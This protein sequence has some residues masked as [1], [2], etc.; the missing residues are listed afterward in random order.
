MLTYLSN[1][2]FATSKNTT[3]KTNITANK[4]TVQKQQ[5]VSIEKNIAKYL[6]KVPRIFYIIPELNKTKITKL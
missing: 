6:E 1:N 2:S 3:P 4:K 5:K